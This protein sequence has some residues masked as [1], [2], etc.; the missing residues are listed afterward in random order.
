[1]DSINSELPPMSPDE[2]KSFTEKL[3]GK[4]SFV[5][6]VAA[7]TG[8][9]TSAAEEAVIGQIH[10]TITKGDPQKT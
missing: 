4:L 1:M 2:R 10:D 9:N 6:G 7:Q 8:K 3:L 5:R